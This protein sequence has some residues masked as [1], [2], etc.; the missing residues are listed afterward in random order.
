[1]IRVSGLCSTVMAA[2]AAVAALSLVCFSGGPI[3]QTRQGDCRER[4]L[5]EAP[6][7]WGRLRDSMRTAIGTESI[8]RQ[9]RSTPAARA[10]GYVAD[11]RFRN[12]AQFW[13]TPSA[14]KAI[15]D[16][17]DPSGKWLGRG[18]YCYN[19]RYAF[20]LRQLVSGGPYVVTMEGND[21]ATMEKVR[22]AVAHFSRGTSAP[23]DMEVD[24]RPL[25]DIVRGADCSILDCRDVSEGGRALVRVDFTFELTGRAAAENPGKRAASVVLDP[26]E[27][28]RIV[29][30][31]LQQGSWTI[32]TRI[33]YSSN[34]PNPA[35]IARI[36][37][38]GAST[39]GVTDDYDIEFT[40]LSFQPTPEAEF[41]LSAFGLPE[42]PAPRATAVTRL[43]W[44]GALFL[45][46]ALL[47][48][49]V[50]RR[51]RNQR[52]FGRWGMR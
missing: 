38:R 41:N 9:I 33:S 44:I 10:Q 21:P 4:F 3:A 43:T 16:G 35:S 31:A 42:P 36:T 50:Y 39:A 18:A 28:W 20:E 5:T 51:E 34:G 47:L 6:A 17:Y 27:D 26:N 52:G 46:L 22:L 1:M 45:A 40:S 49:L 29:K 37:E 23:Y 13:F 15:S 7:A 11:Y 8:T 14:G 19:P 25:S 48:Y 2:R 32:P 30:T 24:V 12:V